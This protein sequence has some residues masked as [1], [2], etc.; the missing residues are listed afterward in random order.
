MFSLFTGKISSVLSLAFQ[1]LSKLV[2]WVIETASD[3]IDTVVETVGSITTPLTEQLTQLP[4]VGGTVEA[5]LDLQSNLVGQLSDGLDAI[6]HDLSQGDLLGGVSTALNGLTST[7]GQAIE[8]T[9]GVVE[10]LVALSSPITGLISDL[11][12][13]GDVL[14]AADQTTS[15]LIGFVEEI[16]Q[17]VGS[18]NPTELVS[19]LLSDPAGSVGGVVQDASATL[20][21]LL[22][23]LVP[24]TDW[25]SEL[26]VVGDVV[27]QVGETANTIN[28]AI[29]D[30]GTQI[31]QIDLLSPFNQSQTYA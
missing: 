6:A 13:L 19:G 28:Q 14:D 5:V 7:A 29:Y 22:N 1:G 9:A 10:Q 3:V 21:N 17:Y 23:D 27:T 12:G 18:I 4:V 2:G 25:A 11:P 30:V 31:S 16:G 8:H 26:P 15:Y 24:V 20:E